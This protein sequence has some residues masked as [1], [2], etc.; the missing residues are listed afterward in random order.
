MWFK[1]KTAEEERR[2]LTEYTEATS[3]YAKAARQLERRRAT[4][5]AVEYHRL[6][7]ICEDEREACENTRL[8]LQSLRAVSGLGSIPTGASCVAENF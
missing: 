5:S 6:Y 3:S 7:E 4:A 1:A 2:L 8:A